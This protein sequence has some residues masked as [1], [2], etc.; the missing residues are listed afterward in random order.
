MA[1]PIANVNQTTDTFLDWLDKTNQVLDNLSTKIITTEAN[2][3][4]G[5]T[6][7]NA[8]VNGVFS[9]NVFS[10]V[11]G[12]RGGSV[13][14]SNV[15]YVVSNTAF[16]N[17][18]SNVFVLTTNATT[19]TLISNVA[20][21]N[22]NS[23]NTNFNTGVL[24]ISANV[25]TTSNLV[26][27]NNNITN[28]AGNTF[29]ITSTNTLIYSSLTVNNSV[30]VVNTA[31]LVIRGGNT[32]FISNA[33]FST[34]ATF[35]DAIVVTGNGTYSGIST[36]NNL[37]NYNANV[38]FGSGIATFN[39]NVAFA[40]ANVS[41]NNNLT[42]VSGNGFTISTNTVFNSNLTVNTAL[43]L[44]NTANLTI[45][46]GNT[47]FTA[48]NIFSGNT[49]F[50]GGFV[51][52][53]VAKFNSS[54][55]EFANNTLFI[56]NTNKRIAVGS[57]D[58]SNALNKVY[59]VGNTLISANLY[60]SDRIESNIVACNTFVV[61]G[62]L[63]FTGTSNGNF[64]P[65]SNAYSLGNTTNR[66][67]VF[68]SSGVFANDV[69]VSGN[70]TLSQFLDVGK[71]TTIGG[72]ATQV[73]FAANATSVNTTTE[74]I[75][76]AAHGFSNG[77]MLYYS[78]G[79]GNT[80]IGGLTDKESYFVRDANSTAFRLS[81]TIGGSS[82]NLTTTG[83][84]TGHFFTRN[85]INLQTQRISIGNTTVNTFITPLTIETDGSLVVLGETS[86]SNVLSTGNT[87]VT[88]FIN[89]T[90]T[91]NVGGVANFRAN[92]VANGQ[93]IV[94]NTASL[95]NTDITGFI[96]VT[97]TA[98]VGGIAN[99]R[100][101]V[102]SNGQLIVANT[103][104]LGNTTTSGFSNV[105][106]IVTV[107][108]ART[109]QSFNAA[110][111][112]N[113]GSE[114]ITITSHGF[115]NNDVVTYI[116][117]AGNTA[118]SGLS[119]GT[120]YFIV[121]A[122]SNTFKLASSQN[123]SALNITSGANE[124]GH[125][126]ITRSAS[127]T[128]DRV[129]VGNSSVNTFLT[130]LAIETDGSLTVTGVST[131]SGNVSSGNTT[132]TGFANISS[133]LAA[134]NTSVSGTLAT[135]NTTVTGFA[136]VTT[137]LAAGNTTITGFANVSTTIFGGTSLTIGSD[138]FVVANTSALRVGN[139]TV[140]NIITHNQIKVGNN[141]VNSDL[142]AGVLNVGSNVSLNVS[143]LKIGNSTVNVT[144]TSSTI[145][146]GN[147]SVN[148]QIT[149]NGIVGG[150]V[151][152]SELNL[153]E[154]SVANTINL[155]DNTDA[156]TISLLARITN[157]ANT[158]DISF[159]N[160]SVFAFLNSSSF[161]VSN[162]SGNGASITSV[163]AS[164]VGGNTAL[165]LRTLSE[166]AYTNA[167]AIAVNA[168]NI[169]TG[170][171]SDARLSS[172]VVRTSINIIAANGITGSANLAA[173]VS[174]S[175]TGQAL[176][177]HNLADNGFIVRTAANTVAARTITAAN[178]VSITNGNGVSA[179]PEITLTGQAL[180]LHNLA[181]NGFVVRT[182]SGSFSA[183]SLSSGTGISITN[184]DGVSGNPTISATF[185][186]DETQIRS[187]FVGTGSPTY[188]ANGTIHATNDIVAHYSDKRLKEIL[189]PIPNALE[190]VNS[191][192]GYYYKLNDTARNLGYTN[193]ETQVGVIAQEIE[194]VLPEVIRAAPIDPQ[195]MTV[196]Y[197]KITPL[198][199]EA[200]KELNKKV[201]DLEERL[202]KNG[203][204]S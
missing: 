155:G 6:S 173:N 15:L 16:T 166:Q 105:T 3:T 55:T 108:T 51:V 40:A 117:A 162:L 179:A 71:N 103:A 27:L 120:S 146:I 8:V 185:S 176:A 35:S 78:I 59:V 128:P 132:I 28:V 140:N 201:E 12:I 96:N 193:E 147:S 152:L 68:G 203:S 113:S 171:L 122:D 56:D 138:S 34:V 81:T 79:A 133:T 83:S 169:N 198:L 60:V 32:T 139:S 131:L 192:T 106:S 116:V 14:S 21:V 167:V 197:E 74:Y 13:D 39:A 129:S 115:V 62:D 38:V 137:T 29:V 195:Y 107:G 46:G 145:S 177:L 57:D 112:V 181:T 172:N 18:T 82:A 85:Q 142:N 61:Q 70:T 23:T 33:T 86:L 104:S 41:L 127:L 58:T 91:A 124:T 50:N 178:G 194:K 151:S 119:N 143:A 17:A 150:S 63:S 43:A 73:Q 48:N 45:Q 202:N 44:V 175:L 64:V 87:S 24:T 135:G 5:V 67:A 20:T 163:N 54:N 36:Y 180:A 49:F 114:T 141:T 199:I 89:V 161:S 121:E 160:S 110:S 158:T 204:E 182:A 10:V 90:S 76:I 75:A 125:S 42:T 156:N 200:I 88:G 170:T 65:S 95:G 174:L 22:I 19:S 2:T 191:L 102:I 9:A 98:N 134:G 165:T 1:I 53:T 189:G 118:L 25:N 111:N 99:F 69:S 148:T 190:K 126:F 97:S 109:T 186:T 93:L 187:L 52:N 130:P 77:D 72:S 47:N 100:A 164:T 144:V 154:L 159:G 123:G 92:V 30:S 157:Q 149:A 101:N 31:N 7:G 136:N 37:T 94:A 183:R 4:G 168:N 26:T 184:S 11:T 80:V 66:W 188:G 196:L 84:G 153:T